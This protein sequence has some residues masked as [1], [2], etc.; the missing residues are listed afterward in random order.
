MSPSPTLAPTGHFQLQEVAL[1]CS[2][3]LEKVGKVHRG[4]P[5]EFPLLK[6]GRGSGQ[7]GLGSEQTQIGDDGIDGDIV[8]LFSWLI[9]AW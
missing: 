4:P 5:R 6:I 9:F 2:R 7:G 8:A 1:G 3:G